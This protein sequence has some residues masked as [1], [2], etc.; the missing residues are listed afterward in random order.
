[1]TVNYPLM[2]KTLLGKFQTEQKSG[3][4]QVFNGVINK[5]W[6]HALIF[7]N[8]FAYFLGTSNSSNIFPCYFCCHKISALAC[9]LVR[10]MSVICPQEHYHDRLKVRQW[11]VFTRSMSVFYHIFPEINRTSFFCTF[12]Q[13]TKQQSFFLSTER[14]GKDRNFPGKSN[15]VLICKMAPK[16]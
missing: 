10:G 9:L 5:K 16:I 12:H 3:K 6:A 7:F 4:F 11:P 8:D 1:M 14:Y 2:I 15:F 13:T